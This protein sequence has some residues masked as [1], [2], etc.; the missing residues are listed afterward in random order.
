MNLRE[1]VLKDLERGMRLTLRIQDEIDP[2]FR[3]A[4][5][6]GDLHVAITFPEDPSERSWLMG[7]F[8]TYLLAKQA[9]A[10]TLVTELARPE[11]LFAAGVSFREV[12][13]ASIHKTDSKQPWTEKSFSDPV[14]HRREDVGDDIVDLLPRGAG[15]INEADL[16]ELDSLFGTEGRFPVVNIKMQTLERL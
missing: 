14:W 11:C 15:A 9:V 5:L 3:I 4:T 2:Q 10:F 12:V 6:G 16:V 13:A 1:I 8:R 7:R